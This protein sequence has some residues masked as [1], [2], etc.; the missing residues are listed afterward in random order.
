MNF[1]NYLLNKENIPKHDGRALWK[2]NLTNEDFNLL[3]QNL[4][5]CTSNNLDPRAATFIYAEWWKNNYNGGIPSKMTIFNSLNGNV[6]YYYNEN[7]FYK[8]AI[9]GAEILGVKWI[10][11]QNTLYFRTLLLQGGLPL[12][13][14]SEN[15]GKYQAFLLAVLEKQPETIED[16]IFES[17]ITNLLPISSQNNIIYENCLEIVKSILNDENIY[18]DLIKNDNNEILKTIF[19]TLK[20][21]KQ[22]LKKRQ[23]LSI[24]KNYWLLSFQKEKTNINLQIGLA[25]K[26]NKES[27]S[28][29]LGFEAND[30]EYQL[31]VNDE[32]ICVFK[33]MINGD[34]KTDWFQ[35]QNKKWN[36]ESNL[37]TTYVISDGIKIEVVDFIQTIPDLHQPSLWSKYSDNEWRL[38][39]GNGASNTELALLFP[40]NWESNQLSKDILISNKDLSW[41][42]FEG[43]VSLRFEH[44]VR[45]YFTD[46]ESF[47]WIIESQKPSWMYKSNMPVVQRKPK[48]IVYND[49]DKPSNRHKIWLKPYKSVTNWEEFSSLENL[50]LGCLEIKIEKGDFKAYD[51][52]FNIGNLTARYSNK[53]IDYANI[54]IRNKDYFEFRLEESPILEIQNKDSVYSLKVNTES[55]IIPTG[56]KGSV[57]ITNQ[58]K[59][60][61]QMASP[62]EGMAIINKNGETITTD[63]KITFNNIYGLR[64]LCSPN[65]ETILKIKN[66]L[67]PDVVINKEIK[68]SSQPINS[69]KDEI[70]R[71]YYLADAMDY[72]NKVSI[73]LIEGRNSKS[74]EISGFSNTL[75]VQEQLENKVSLYEQDQELELELYAVPLNCKSEDITLIPLIKNENYYTIPST[76]ITNQFIVISSKENNNQLMPRFVNTKEEFNSIAKEIR[77]EKYHLALLKS[78]FDDEIWKQLLSYLNICIENNLPFSTFDQIR[79]IS[80]SSLVAAR[81]FFFI[82]SNQID[83][84]NFIQKIIPEM[85]MDL[86]FCFHWIKKE[87]WEFALNEIDK[88]YNNQYFNI[89]FE[90]LSIYMQEIG[91]TSILNDNNTSRNIHNSDIRELRRQLG[92]RVLNELPINSPWI[93]KTYN[94][95]IN[96]NKQVRLLLQ[97]PIAV[98]ESI[99]GIETDFPIWGGNESR[100]KIRRNIQYSQYLNPEFYN[101][102]ILQVLKN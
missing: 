35:H 28:N 11:K 84:D 3:L 91:L 45:R 58:K 54:E 63:K 15:H 5:N 59:L 25:D 72:K 6:K 66:K 61:F 99:N 102:I 77:I 64:I 69:F 76:E 33:K 8:L 49:D 9:K 38:L 87:D 42:I 82:G 80:R 34:Y 81:A 22:S 7:T 40:T 57:G 20:V 79:A 17:Q 88:M 100:D 68:E 32:L 27:L 37:P 97:A 43:E 93:T 31:Y 75:N 18:D 41:L 73:E 21:K 16:F 90:L 94:I 48:I 10:N 26:Y 101:N 89:F 46:V 86:G 23:R 62:F 14:I 98:A 50:P 44:E 2:Y 52:F 12:A 60:R 36:G 13:H 30:K 92:A 55:L 95:P 85:E 65:T 39:K 1:F 96:D 24:P 70:L 83:K 78:T 4:K 74:Y 29:I 67:K 51:I 53:S 71:L 56:I 19:N 47:D